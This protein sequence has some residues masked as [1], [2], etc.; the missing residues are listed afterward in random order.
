MY[1]GRNF[2]SSRTQVY[3]GVSPCTT[4]DE[5]VLQ[6]TTLYCAVLLCTTEVTTEEYFVLQSTTLYYGVSLCTTEDYFVLQSTTLYYTMLLCDTGLILKSKQK[7]SVENRYD[8]LLQ[9]VLGVKMF[10]SC[11]QVYYGVSLCTTE[12]Y[13]VLQN[14]TLYYTIL[15]CTTE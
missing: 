13:F 5:F 11:T 3:Y 15:L 9:S 1:W 10:S 12:D 2:F 7:R 4:E 8:P 6:S 14:T